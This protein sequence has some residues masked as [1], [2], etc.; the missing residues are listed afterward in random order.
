MKEYPLIDVK[1]SLQL[2]EKVLDSSLFTYNCPN[3]G[4]TTLVAY[5][6]LYVDKDKKLMIRL[7]KDRHDL[8]C[9]ND[10]GFTLRTVSDPNELVEKILLFDLGLDDRAVELEKHIAI[11][12]LHTQQPDLEVSALYFS[13]AE[14]GYQLIILGNGGFEG[15]I[16]W[17]SNLYEKIVEE[18]LPGLPEAVME[19]PGI[20]QDWAQLLFDSLSE[21]E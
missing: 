16:P 6:C 19:G 3:C 9:N 13:P 11:D 1:R 4:Y 12:A 10:G 14:D 20:N 21:E 18:V 15:T 2:K 5:D 8:T 17:D 7:G